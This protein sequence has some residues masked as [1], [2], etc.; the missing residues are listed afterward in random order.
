MM[1][2]LSSRLSWTRP[3][4][5][6]ARLHEAVTE[7]VGRTLGVPAD[8]VRP[9]TSFEELGA[10]SLDRFDLILATEKRFE[11]HIPDEDA[12]R[13]LTVNDLVRYVSKSS[14]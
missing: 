7:L 14:A 3:L 5:A 1:E 2:G 11:L 10:D 9:G 12:E 8:R 6:R 4:A 13:I